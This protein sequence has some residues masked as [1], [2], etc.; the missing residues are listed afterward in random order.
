MVND[1]GALEAKNPTSR[2]HAT[3]LYF[4]KRFFY[5][6]DNSQNAF[7]Y[8]KNGTGKPIAWQ[9]NE[10]SVP[11]VVLV[12][13]EESLER[14]EGAESP[15][16]ASKKNKLDLNFRDTWR[17]AFRGVSVRDSSNLAAVFKTCQL[18]E[19]IF[20]INDI[21][22]FCKPNLLITGLGQNRHSSALFERTY[23][24]GRHIQ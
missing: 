22:S 8:L 1:G 10:K 17:R 12:V 2:F 20:L 23:S 4:L 5:K 19:K 11:C 6:K 16:G 21:N 3:K 9:N 18:L 15:T 7:C 24:T 13:L 14:N